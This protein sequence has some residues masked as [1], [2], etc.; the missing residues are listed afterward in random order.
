MPMDG[1]DVAQMR[2]AASRLETTAEALTWRIQSVD[3]VVMAV[4]WQGADADA[5][6]T[7]HWPSLKLALEAS[8]AHY[9]RISGLLR[10]EAAEQEQVSNG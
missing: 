2:R 1:A 5:F 3:R 6:R 10:A 7:T 4:A 9:R 8:C